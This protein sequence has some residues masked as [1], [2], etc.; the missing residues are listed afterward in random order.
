MSAKYIAAVVQAAPILFDLE[1]TLDKTADLV[2][3]AKAK[4]AQLILFP[5]A[6]IS[7]YP[8]GLSFGTVVGS[9]DPAGRLLWQRYWES[10][11]AEGDAACLRLG[12]M[13]KDA[14]AFLVIG[15]NEK[16]TVSGTLYCSMF[17]FGPNGDF[18]GKHRKIKPTAQE[19]VIWGE[20][21][22]STLSSFDT[23]IG[24]MGGLICWENYM[25]MARMAMYQ[26]GIQ[27]YLAPTADNRDGWQ[28]TM[29]HIALE[30]R[31]FVLGCNQYVTKSMYPTDLPGFQ[32]LENQP[33]VMATGG[34]IIVDPLGK[35]LAEPLWGEEG[36]LTAEIDLDQVIQS[37]LDFDPIGHYNRSDIFDFKVNNQPPIKVID[38]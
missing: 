20:D 5:E 9:R 14:G 23:S 19:R 35:V 4:G 3:Q 1:A 21:N 16:D 31:C 34:S 2:S 13:A 22:G 7:A 10:S 30:G 37:K 26:Q 8:R 29:Q 6:F 11:I 24:K 33:E 32:A 18:L 36:I 28:Q 25:P 15:V 12:Q 38:Q 27:V 17:Y